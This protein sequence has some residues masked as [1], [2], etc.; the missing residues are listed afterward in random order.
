MNLGLSIFLSTILICSVWLYYITRDRWRWNK[1]LKVVAILGGISAIVLLSIFVYNE[2]LKT[3]PIKKEI[4][5]LEESRDERRKEI[6][7]KFKP[8]KLT[9]LGNFELGESQSNI[10]FRNGKPQKIFSSPEIW[11]YRNHGDYFLFFIDKKIV[12]IITDRYELMDK[13]YFEKTE[14]IIMKWGKPQI[15]IDFA[16]DYKKLFLYSKYNLLFTFFGNERVVEGI[17]LVQ[18][19]KEVKE[20]ILSQK[21]F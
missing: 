11:V 5:S 8:E 10:K 17:Y 3:K 20:L 12:S 6:L 14:E 2:F 13:Y 19:E 4:L 18:Y 16:D 9:K 15:E 7:S 21:Y 1:I